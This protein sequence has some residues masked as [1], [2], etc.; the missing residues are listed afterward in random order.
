MEKGTMIRIVDPQSLQNELKHLSGWQV[1]D[2]EKS[3]FKAFKFKSFSESWAFMSRLALYAEKN[4]HHPDWSNS[5]N[6]VKISLSTHE[7]GGITMRD[8]NFAKAAEKYSMA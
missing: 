7:A 8:I 4:D 1:S 6:L 2:D 3:I 5:Y